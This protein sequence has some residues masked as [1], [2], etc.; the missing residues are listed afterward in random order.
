MR[1]FGVGEI[2][3]ARVSIA[4]TLCVGGKDDRLAFDLLCGRS[5]HGDI[6]LNDD[7]VWCGWASLDRDTTREGTEKDG[8]TSS[9]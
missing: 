8:K 1:K 9:I 2:F 5:V 4:R 3:A 6:T 7:G